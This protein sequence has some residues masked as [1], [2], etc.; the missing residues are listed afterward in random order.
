MVAKNGAGVSMNQVVTTNIT[1][2]GE[3]GVLIKAFLA[4]ELREKRRLQ[5]RRPQL[6]PNSDMQAL[7]FTL[8][9]AGHG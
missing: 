3:V 6:D 7:L 4:E 2:P 8:Q 1:H 5:G 9:E